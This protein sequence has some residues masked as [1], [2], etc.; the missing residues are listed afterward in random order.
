M[1]PI[2]ATV[3]VSQV[4]RTYVEKVGAGLPFRVQFP[5]PAKAGGPGPD[6]H[7][8]WVVAVNLKT[9]AKT[10]TLEFV[11]AFLDPLELLSGQ[12]GTFRRVEKN[13]Q[14]WKRFSLNAFVHSCYAGWDVKPY[15]VTPGNIYT[16]PAYTATKVEVRPATWVAFQDLCP[17]WLRQ[18]LRTRQ[19]PPNWTSPLD[20]SSPLDGLPYP[21]RNASAPI[22]KIF[23][24]LPPVACRRQLHVS[25]TPSSDP[26]KRLAA[27]RPKKDPKRLKSTNKRSASSRPKKDPKRSKSTNAASHRSVVTAATRL[28]VLH[29]S[30]PP[31]VES[32][33]DGTDGEED[34]VNSQMPTTE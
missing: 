20:G 21:Q 17:P 3:L 7:T 2:A 6:D 33:S 8:G 22:D 9:T 24:V 12:G 14:V 32:L 15:H 31:E 5:R 10:Q 13:A 27:P 4:V 30:P 28:L 23:G 19:V 11:V 29:H 18:M 34:V 25:A 16:R 1:D 26:A